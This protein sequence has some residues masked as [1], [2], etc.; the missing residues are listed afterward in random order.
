MQKCPPKL[1]IIM[2]QFLPCFS[3]KPWHS[4]RSLLSAK[5][6]P[7]PALTGLGPVGSPVRHNVLGLSRLAKSQEQGWVLSAAGPYGQVVLHEEKPQRDSSNHTNIV[8]TRGGA[9]AIRPPR[10][11]KRLDQVCTNPL[12]T[13][14]YTARMFV[15]MLKYFHY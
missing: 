3:R 8:R 14:I 11:K 10:I 15:H 1:S 12:P 6:T 13:P 4:V 5:P 2:Q 7:V 9:F